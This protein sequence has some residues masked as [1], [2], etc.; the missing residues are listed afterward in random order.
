MIQFLIFLTAYSRK[1]AD[2][3]VS[4]Y[5]FTTVLYLSKNLSIKVVGGLSASRSAKY[6]PPRSLSLYLTA[7]FNIFIQR[8]H[9][10]WSGIGYSGSSQGL[11]VSLTLVA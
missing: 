10:L 2:L 9:L 7:L 4:S 3:P 5:L 8:L 11:T 1:A 6:G